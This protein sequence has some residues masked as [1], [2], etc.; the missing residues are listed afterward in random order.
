MIMLRTG[1]NKYKKKIVRQ[2]GYLQSFKVNTMRYSVIR[3]LLLHSSHLFP[4]IP[5]IYS[6]HSAL[7][8][9]NIKIHPRCSENPVRYS[10][11]ST[12]HRFTLSSNYL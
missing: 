7:L 1:I 11:Q 5:V 6:H 3:K 9:T 10:E 8:Q 12:C 4:V 2:V